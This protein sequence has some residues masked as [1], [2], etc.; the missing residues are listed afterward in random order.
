M[1]GQATK[2]WISLKSS[3][4]GIEWASAYFRSLAFS[5]HRHDTYAIGYTTAGVQSFDYRGQGQHACPGDSFVLHPDEL[6]DG[7]Q[8][9]DEGYGYRIV[10]LAP[11]LVAEA[12]DGAALPFVK[13]PV[14][15]DPRLREAVASS[16]PAPDETAD[17]LHRAASIAALADL[18][19][20][21]AEGCGRSRRPPDPAVMRRVRDHLLESSP[22]A[23]SMAALEREHGIDRYSLS[24]QFRSAFGVSPHRFM[25]LRRLDLAKAQIAAGETLAGAALMAGFAD[26]S[27]MTRRFRA[28]YG[29]SPGTW[30]RLLT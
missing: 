20:A 6:H 12:L 15:N 16:F 13:A 24:R 21:L 25:T 11:N 30:R 17:E 2:S 7:R 4:G 26:Q 22:S 19:S 29:L 28:A 18:L 10:Y 8:G 14:T 3:G 9:T 5:P 23:V 1:T 27:H